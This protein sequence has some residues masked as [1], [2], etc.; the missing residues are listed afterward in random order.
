MAEPRFTL[1]APLQVPGSRHGGGHDCCIFR[2]NRHYFDRLGRAMA[3]RLFRQVSGYE[4]YTPSAEGLKADHGAAGGLGIGRIMG[5]HQH[6]N[7][8]V[9]DM[10]EDEAAH[11]LAQRG[12]EFREGF[13]EQ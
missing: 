2:R 6:G 8:A 10:V 1:Q 12:V 3:R 13:V 7:V 4:P 11:I 9:A 5:D